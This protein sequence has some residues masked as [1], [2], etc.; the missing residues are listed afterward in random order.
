MAGTGSVFAHS[1]FDPDDVEVVSTR[2]PRPLELVDSDPSWP[3]QFGLIADRLR[4]ALGDRAL[5]V[6]HVGSTSVPGLPAKPVVDVDL[7][8][9]DSAAEETYADDLTAAGF[10]F[11]LREPGWHQH[12]LFGSE[13]PY[14]NVHVFGPDSPELVRHVVFRDWLRRHPEDR[15]RYVAA[16]R[17][18]VSATAADETVGGY[19][20][21]RA[22]N[23][24]KQTVVRDIL[25]RALA[26][27]DLR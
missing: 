25:D 5:S 27:A 19:D 11:L 10:V 14:G 13:E 16:K 3:E 12:R 20:P 4:T 15:E 6:E 8:V 1:T 21:V 2:T 26:A 24:R 23:A 18:A 22:Y 17:R 7:V 9:A